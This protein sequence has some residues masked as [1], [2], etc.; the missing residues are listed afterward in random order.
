MVKRFF[1]F[2]GSAG[3][4]PFC[5]KRETGACTETEARD[6]PGCK[7]KILKFATDNMRII[8]Y[9]FIGAILLQAALLAIVILTICL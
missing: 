6:T 2:S 7:D 3:L 4:P 5:C 9:V 1:P 8:M